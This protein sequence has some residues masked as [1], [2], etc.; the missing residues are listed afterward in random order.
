MCGTTTDVDGTTTESYP[1]NKRAPDELPAS[2]RY[3]RQAFGESLGEFPLHETEARVAGAEGNSG[4]AST[5]TMGKG[6]R[7][8]GHAAAVEGW[9]WRRRVEEEGGLEQDKIAIRI[10]NGTKRVGGGQLVQ[11][12]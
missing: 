1:E 2:F 6:Y 8:M 10:K 11:R 5:G 3:L 4:M 9:R 7:Q 12:I